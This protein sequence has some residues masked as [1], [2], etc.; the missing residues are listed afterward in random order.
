MMLP[1]NGECSA[2]SGLMREADDNELKRSEVCVS[3]A[4]CRY[5]S[6]YVLLCAC[7]ALRMYCLEQDVATGRASALQSSQRECKRKY[8]QS[9]A[10]VRQLEHD[11]IFCVNRYMTI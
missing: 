10:V 11:E 6:V 3:I 8:R 4:L 7:I 5:C 9:Q 2:C 1:S